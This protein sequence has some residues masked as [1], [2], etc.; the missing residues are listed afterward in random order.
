M[1]DRR[2]LLFSR[3]LVT[4][5]D[6]AASHSIATMLAVQ[7]YRNVERL[8]EP[9]RLSE[10]CRRN[11]I[12]L[13]LLAVR[14]PPYES[15]ELISQLHGQAG[16]QGPTVIA[17]TEPD[18]VH[19]RIQALEF[20]ARDCLTRPFDTR[21]ALQRVHNALRSRRLYR[22]RESQAAELKV[23]ADR[24]TA[25]LERLALEEPITGRPNRRALRNHLQRC[26][27]QALP[28]IYLLFIALDGLDDIARLH[29]YPASDA[30]LCHACQ[31]IDGHITGS[32]M[33]GCWGGSELL[34]ICQSLRDDASVSE[35]A[36]AIHASLARDHLVDKLLVS[37]G[38]RIG[39][40][41]AGV[42]ARCPE[43]LVRLATLALPLQG[44]PA[45]RTYSVELEHHH[46]KRARI[47]QLMREAAPGGELHLVYQPKVHL[48]T[49]RI[50]GVEALVRWNSAELGI[51]PPGEFVPLAEANGDILAIGDWVVDETIRQLTECAPKARSTSISASPSTSP[52]VSLCTAISPFAC[53]RAC[54]GP[55]CPPMPCRSRSPNQ[56]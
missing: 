50:V 8:T 36:E 34:L 32:D 33:L 51:I 56:G 39:I 43:Q 1:P 15:L 12:D 38:C 40:S 6:P 41:Y 27:N 21:E 37:L 47:Q 16:L 46:Q 11:P 54:S 25:E 45:V 52:P 7:G 18:D 3:I 13:V 48:T 22:Q 29:G 4:E 24:R 30:L 23:L 9:A 35:R 17:L 44:A 2:A 55:T 14:T 31:L 42:D 53:C 5:A 26:L 19:V 49:G 10:Y 28:N 20:G